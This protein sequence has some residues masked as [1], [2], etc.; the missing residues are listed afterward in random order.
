MG[1][2]AEIGKADGIFWISYPDF[3]RNFSDIYLC[4]FFDE[5]Y[6]E[7]YFESEWSKEKATAGGCM[8]NKTFEL[9]PQ[10]LVTVDSDRDGVE[11]YMQLFAFLGEG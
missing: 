5:E 3:Y 10:M 2:L 6:E 9:N 7:F 8:N 1:E 11:V 4:R